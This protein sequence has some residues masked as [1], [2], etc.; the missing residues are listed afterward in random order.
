M[1]LTNLTG[2]VVYIVFY[3]GNT[4][5]VHI[6]HLQPAVVLSKKIEKYAKKGLRYW[7][8]QGSAALAIGGDD[9][10][11]QSGTIGHRF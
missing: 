4:K 3:A 11:A 9:R 10:P 1:E 8:S 7:R 6:A 5:A 2:K